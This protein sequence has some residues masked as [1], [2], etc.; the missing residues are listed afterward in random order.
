MAQLEKLIAKMRNQPQ[1]WTI[2]DVEKVA[3]HFGFTKRTT[4]GSH[5][6]FSHEQHAH[7]LTVPA[8]K[9]IKPVYIKRLFK[10]IDEVTS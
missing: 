7:I 9:P 1:G 3:V 8:H 6:T 4:S 10:L 2:Q 5:V